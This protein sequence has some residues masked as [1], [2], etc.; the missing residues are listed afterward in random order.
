MD[1][2]GYA[3]FSITTIC[4]YFQF[5]LLDS[6]VWDKEVVTLVVRIPSPRPDATQQNETY[7]GLI[8]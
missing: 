8:C 5:K 3:S 6:E 7:M 2:F 4:N 1:F